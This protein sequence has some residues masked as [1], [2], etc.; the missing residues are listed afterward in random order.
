MVKASSGPELQPE[1]ATDPA[2]PTGPNAPSAAWNRRTRLLRSRLSGWKLVD[3]GAQC[4]YL[5]FYV[6]PFSRVCRSITA[7]Q[8]TALKLG[9]C[10]GQ[11][12]DIP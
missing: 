12:F 7:R 9:Y 5:D 6:G 3:E 10:Y 2:L 11:D 4:D 1:E 8:G